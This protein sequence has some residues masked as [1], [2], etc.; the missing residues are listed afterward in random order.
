M[1]S[2]DAV[3]VVSCLP[4]IELD[5]SL[6]LPTD[7][8]AQTSGMVAG[9]LRAVGI[10]AV[11]IQCCWKG[12]CARER[13]QRRLARKKEEEEKIRNSLKMAEV[14]MTNLK[15]LD[16]GDKTGKK[17]TRKRSCLFNHLIDSIDSIDSIHSPIHPFTHSFTP[18]SPTSR[19]HTS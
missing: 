14:L 8:F 16:G 1:S 9:L 5:V 3:R 6:L 19:A 17:S 7:A 10:A 15:M 12:K 4:S 11:R 18:P 2:R 13:I